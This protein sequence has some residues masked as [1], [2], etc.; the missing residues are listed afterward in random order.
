[1]LTSA[2]M[3]EIFEINVFWHSENESTVHFS[4]KILVAREKFFCSSLSRFKGFEVKSF[5]I[6]KFQNWWV[7][8]IFS[9]LE[10]F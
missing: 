3:D 1:M 5:K 7:K 2:D 10:F 8:K 4:I 9:K 6:S